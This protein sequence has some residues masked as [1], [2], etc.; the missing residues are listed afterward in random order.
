MDSPSKIDEHL[1]LGSEWNA[2]NLD[3]LRRNGYNE[4]CFL[5]QTKFFLEFRNDILKN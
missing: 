1:Y 4:L 5:I 2:S 3:E